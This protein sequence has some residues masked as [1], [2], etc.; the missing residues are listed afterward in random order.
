MLAEQEARIPS[1]R[2]ASTSKSAWVR[3]RFIWGPTECVEDEIMRINNTWMV[4]RNDPHVKNFVTIFGGMAKRLVAWAKD[5]TDE[6]LREWTDL[7]PK[8]RE[9]ARD[10][11]TGAET[12]QH[13]MVY[14]DV[15]TRMKQLDV[16]IVKNPYFG[17]PEYIKMIKEGVSAKGAKEA[18]NYNPRRADI[19]F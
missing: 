16:V 14:V 4:P 2:K 11:P 18:K 7:N 1:K 12:C 6:E 5:I 15:L 13:W 17:T 19:S 9:V 3:K 8:Y 10:L